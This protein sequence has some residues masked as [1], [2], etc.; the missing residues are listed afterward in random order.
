VQELSLQSRLA[1][2]VQALRDNLLQPNQKTEDQP[3]SVR[4]KHRAEAPAVITAEIK[5]KVF[6][7]Q[8]VVLAVDPIALLSYPDGLQ[9]FQPHL[10]GPVLLAVAKQAPTLRTR[11]AS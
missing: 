7:L 1:V 5:A 11:E 3:P 4:F 9:M 10:A 2:A 8:E 6:Q